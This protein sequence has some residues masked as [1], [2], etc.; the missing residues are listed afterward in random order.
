MKLGQLSQ[1]MTPLSAD[2]SARH[3]IDAVDSALGVCNGAAVPVVLTES[4]ECALIYPDER[5]KRLSI[6]IMVN[7]RN[8]IDREL[9]REAGS[10]YRGIVRS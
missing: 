7:G 3:W 4:K 2:H 6:E 10:D 8:V 9:W 1:R 5:N